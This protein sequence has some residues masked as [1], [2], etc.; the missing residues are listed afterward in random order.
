[1]VTL[2][3]LKEFLRVAHDEDDAMLTE[4]LA[5]AEDDLLIFVGLTEMPAS[6]PSL[7]LAQKMLVR[8]SY[9]A[10]TADDAGRWRDVAQRIANQYR[11]NMGV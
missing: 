8:A 2:Q 9:D 1:M 4:L 10:A 3:S 6:A 7:E 5:A 11:T